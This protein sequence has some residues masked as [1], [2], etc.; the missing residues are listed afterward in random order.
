MKLIV[1]SHVSIRPATLLLSLSL[2]LSLLCF[3]LLLI[4]FFCLVR[5]CASLS[6]NIK[7]CPRQNL[8]LFKH[9]DRHR[10][11]RPSCWSLSRPRQEKVSQACRTDTDCCAL[12][13]WS[14]SQRQ[15]V[16]QALRTD[17]DCCALS[18]WSISPRQKI[19]EAP[20]TIP[21]CWA[22]SCWSLSLPRRDRKLVK[23][24]RQRLASLSLSLYIYIYIS[25][26][27]SQSGTSGN[28][29]N[30]SGDI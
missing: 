21:D 27:E 19:C 3:L 15:K 10:L 5:A 24:S 28:Q 22:L 18:C 26:T 23:H 7:A 11:L 16:S 29:S 1:F 2:S 25:K 4:P 20:R 12:S 9:P 8:K 13:C 6:F 17:T 14:L 30:A